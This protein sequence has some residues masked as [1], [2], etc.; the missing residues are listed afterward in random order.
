MS[1][2]VLVCSDE[3]HPHDGVE[4]PTEMDGTLLLSIVQ[5]Q[6]DKATGLKYRLVYQ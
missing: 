3:A 5:S 1:S 2:C 6:F 4:L